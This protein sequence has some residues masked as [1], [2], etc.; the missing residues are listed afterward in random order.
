[1]SEK[2]I[3]IFICEDQKISKEIVDKYF[4]NGVTFAQIA[5]ADMRQE[6]SEAIGKACDG[7]PSC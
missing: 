7:V 4:G 1:M 3:S 5:D 2:E 6:I